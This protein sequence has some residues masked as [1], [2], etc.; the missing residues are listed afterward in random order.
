MLCFFKH[1]NVS[2]VGVWDNYFQSM[3]NYVSKEQ[4]RLK[5][6]TLPYKGIWKPE[7]K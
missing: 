6:G 4:K 3:F 5:K 7:T 2:E 1:D